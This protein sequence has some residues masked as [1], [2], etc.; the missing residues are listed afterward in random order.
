M[1]TLWARIDDKTGKPDTDRL[2]GKTSDR[3]MLFVMRYFDID[4]V[5]KKKAYF[6]A[7]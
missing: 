2:W 7:Q 6:F 3:D 1:L 4:P 5:L